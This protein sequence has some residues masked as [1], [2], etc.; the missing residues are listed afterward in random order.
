MMTLLIG[1]RFLIDFLDGDV[2]YKIRRETHNLD[3]CRVQ[4][5]LV[6]SIIEHEQEMRA[7]L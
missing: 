7:A 6:E 2:Y 1:M 5:K 4:F 3:R